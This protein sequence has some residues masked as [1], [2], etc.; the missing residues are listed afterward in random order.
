MHPVFVVESTVAK[1]REWTGMEFP[2]SG[3]YI[4]PG[5][6]VPV[7][8]DLAADYGTY[9]EPNVWTAHET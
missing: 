7:T 9:V 3:E 1:W 8:I 2:R 6:L 4:V 5:A